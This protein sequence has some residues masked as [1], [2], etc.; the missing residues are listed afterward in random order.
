M[1]NNPSSD[2]HDL[3]V[4]CRSYTKREKCPHV[5]NVVKHI[6]VY[7]VEEELPKGIICIVNKILFAHCIVFL[8][9]R[10]ISQMW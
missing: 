7:Y 2:K 4:L 3:T 9:I 6:I 10:K 5:A 1:S 8:G